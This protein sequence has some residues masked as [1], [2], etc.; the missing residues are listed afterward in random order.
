MTIPLRVKL[1]S[2]LFVA[3]L[4]GV[5]VGCVW[6]VSDLTSTITLTQPVTLVV[7][8]AETITSTIT[9]TETLT[10]ISTVNA[11]IP[12]DVRFSPKGGAASLLI[13]WIDRANESIHVLIYSF[14]S[15]A[16][17][18]ALITAK[19]RGVDVKV[20]FDDQ[21]VDVSG[22]EYVKLKD[23]G[24]EVRVDA[25]SSLMH[26]KVAIIDR[27]VLVTGSYNWSRAAEESNRENLIV[28]RDPKLASLYEEEFSKI[29]S[30]SIEQP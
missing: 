7:T 22:S 5:V 26:N 4:G 6:S 14:T 9:K 30:A 20:V 21:Q 18:A 3:F 19:Q 25:R 28:L 23:A 13:S 11:T 17:S 16:I 2:V 8:K 10:T 29:W 24:V 12:W 27:L 15:D 1:A